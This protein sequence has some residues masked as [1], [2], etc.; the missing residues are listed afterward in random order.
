MLKVCLI[1]PNLLPVPA[2]K[3]GAIETIVTNL[4]KEQEK[5][6]KLD[7]TIVSIYDEKA[8]RESKK[9][10]NTKFIYIKKDFSYALKSVFYKIQ[11]KVLK[12][13]LN[14]YNSTV[15][16]KIKNG[17]FDYVV[18]EGGHYESF[19]K[20]LKFFSK[21]Q[22]VIHLH[23]Q[24]TPN[25]IIANTFSKVVSVSK[26]V[27]DDYLK[28]MN[29]FNVKVLLN[30]VETEK[31]IKNTTK[32]ENVALK[33]KY[34]IKDEDFVV[35]FCGR[36]IKEKGVLELI[37][38]I[39]NIN[40]PKIKLMILGSNS[41]SDNIKTE[42]IEQLEKESAKLKDKIIFTGYVNN[43]DIYKYYAI[44]NIM[45]MP[46][47]CEE[48]AGLTAIEAMLCGKTVLA[49][50]SGGINEYIDKNE[51]VMFDKNKN[52]IRNLEH[53]LK[54]LY[55]KKDKIDMKSKKLINHAQQFNSS[56]M[57][58]DFYEIMNQF[59]N[60]DNNEKK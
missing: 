21:E 57:Y 45:C 47:M 37:K 54:K 31:F 26:F 7:L 53:E 8:E 5:E 18:A 40:N 10:K 9:Y 58:N 14:T 25:E 3:G 6:K 56:N 36:L 23:H 24:G 13:T 27:K 50:N 51:C 39:K 55:D 44:S 30:G 38:A 4:I 41:F 33:K 42:Y 32:K 60:E 35:M 49:A 12:K 1:T 11:N 20:Y 46:S 29:K 43:A 19:A 15:L 59:R 48:A 2:V 16:D 34:N 22:M 28:K 52:C 17:N